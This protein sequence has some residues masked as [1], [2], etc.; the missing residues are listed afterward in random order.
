MDV[1]RVSRLLSE[2]PRH[3]KETH[4]RTKETLESHTNCMSLYKHENAGIIL[5]Q[6]LESVFKLVS[7]F[8]FNTLISLTSH[9]GI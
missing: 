4:R 7:S 5:N 1:P 6:Y 8:F 9:P 3:S 2:T